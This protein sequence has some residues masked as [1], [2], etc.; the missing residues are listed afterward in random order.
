MRA[1]VVGG[2]AIGQFIAAR[3]AQGG[4][5]AVI[6]ARAAQAQALSARGV[7]LRVADSIWNFPILAVADGTDS[8]V[9]D[10]FELV[11]V[12]VKSYSTIEAAASIRALPAT[13]NSTILTVQNGLGN[14]EA[15]AAEFGKERIVSGA[16]TVAVDRVDD[17]TITASK[18]G[19]LS[20][21]PMGHAAENWLLATMS[22]AGLVV[23]AA[24][25]WR[26]L[27][28]SKLCI[29]ILG[30]GVCAALDWTP[31]QVYRDPRAFAVERQC[32]VE[33]IA[34]MD[35][36]RLKPIDLVDFP[37]TRL[38][39]AA[40]ILPAPLLSALLSKR[41]AGGRD[42]KLPSLLMDLRAHKT[43]TEVGALNGAVAR[44]AESV[45]L[46]APANA[47]IAAIVEGIASGEISWDDYRGHPEKLM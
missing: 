6:L 16:L 10:A 23:R 31:D 14:E 41:V 21:A 38:V 40:R 35:A 47:R 1:L 30:N 39:A 11:V 44:H 20:L 37:V 2:G 13:N 4:H 24:R 15:L 17:T 42:G 36:L 25:D 18:K 29:N 26:G 9:G 43:R 33:A 19:G 22:G 46:K 7:T 32:L 45:G 12:A 34:A 8:K 28:W 3:I 27:K 5:D